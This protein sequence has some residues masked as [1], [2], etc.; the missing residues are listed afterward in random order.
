MYINCIFIWEGRLVLSKMQN[1]PKANERKGSWMGWSSFDL[2]SC[3]IGWSSV[4]PL[5]SSYSWH[6][7]HEDFFSL[8]LFSVVSWLVSSRTAV[9]T[10][11][12]KHL[13]Q[14]S[15]GI[16]ID[17]IFSPWVL[18]GNGELENP[19]ADFGL[20]MCRYHSP[21][22][23]YHGHCLIIRNGMSGNPALIKPFGMLISITSLLR[24]KCQGMDLQDWWKPLE[25]ACKVSEKS[26][27]S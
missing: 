23:S 6:V 21:P 26:P 17:L 25:R 13:F 14:G 27:L 4:F 22:L 8:L 7:H 3:H 9:M 24:K 5:S 11:L 20:N 1:F 19:N 16:L 10:L 18:P 12:C 2:G 15:C